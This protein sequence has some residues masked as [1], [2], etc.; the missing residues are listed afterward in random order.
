MF[1]PDFEPKTPAPATDK[2]D[3]TVT[4]LGTASALVLSLAPYV[5]ADDVGMDRK[6]FLRLVAGRILD[7]LGV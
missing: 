1:P 2:P 7:D 6:E 3:V 4:E 5:S